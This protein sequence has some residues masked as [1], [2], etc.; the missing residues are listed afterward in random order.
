MSG[1]LGDAAGSRWFRR[2]ERGA[3]AVE[4]ALVLP[5]LVMLLMGIITG[6]LA[7][8]NSI[9][10]ANAVREG[11]RFGATADLTSGTWRQDVVDRT[12]QTQLDDLGTPPETTVCVQVLGGGSVG[13][14]CDSG[15]GNPPD[16]PT[17]TP[18]PAGTCMVVVVGS[19][20]Y[21]LNFVF[22]RFEGDLVRRSVARYERSCS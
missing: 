1:Q 21:R 2:R 15:T 8:S 18:P 6:G 4:F 19:R 7:Y 10:L 16:Q 11:A 13:W 20:P 3:V 14:Q 17:F 9:G 5:L 22:G 12:R